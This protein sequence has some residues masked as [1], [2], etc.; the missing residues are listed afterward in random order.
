MGHS[1]PGRASSRSGDVRH[2]A[3]SGS[4]FRKSVKIVSGTRV[5]RA[6]EDNIE[7]VERFAFERLPA[8]R[9]QPKAGK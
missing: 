7:Q 3:E 1:R 8:R 4:N 2:A 5:H 9:N 6:Y